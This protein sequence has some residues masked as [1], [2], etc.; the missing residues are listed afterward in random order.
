MLRAF[1]GLSGAVGGLALVVFIGLA[2]ILAH[3]PINLASL[4]PAIERSLDQRFGD[5]YVFSLGPTSIGRGAN[6]LGL[7]VEGLDIKDRSGHSVLSAPTGHVGLDFVSLMMF[8]VKVKRLEIDKIDLRLTVQPNGSVSLAAAKTP[9]AVTIDL[10]PPSSGG[11]SETN[12]PLVRLAALIDAITGAAQTVD[13][14]AIGQGHL[15]I[16]DQKTG[17][18]AAF[19][20]VDINFDK[21]ERV[22][23]LRISAKGPS[24]PWSLAAQALGGESRSLNLEA[25]D[26]SLPD[27]LLA[28]GRTLPF[29]ADMPISFNLSLQLAGDKTV[30]D[31]RGRVSLGAGYFKLD[32]PD[33]EPFLIDE[34]SADV[35][36]DPPS[37][38]ILAENVQLFAGQTHVV[39][40]GAVAP[41]APGEQSWSLDF[42]GDGA[43]I[44]GERPGEQPLAFKTASFQAHYFERDQRFTVDKFAVSGVGANAVL[45]GEI[46]ATA[47]GPT[48]KVKLDMTQTSGANLVR[49]WPTFIV[50][51]VRFWL[52]QHLRAGEI[53]TASLLLDWDAASFTAAREK[54]A[55]PADSVHIELATRDVAIDLLPGV[56]PLI[57]LEATGVLTGRNI[58]IGAK[59]GTVELTP[60]RRI[61]ASDLSFVIPD[62]SPRALVPAQGGARLQGS[63][64]ALAD[65]L[66]RDA[67]KSFVGLSLDP[68]ATKGQFDGK[69]SIDLKLGKTAKPDDIGFHA[70]GT[71]SN[72]Q[73]DKFLGAEHFDQGELAFS[74]DRGGIKISGEGKIAG[75]PVSVDLRK[76][77]SDE[78][79]VNLALSVD[80]AFRAKH[81]LDF[82]AAVSGPMS[83]QIAA[84]LSRKGAEVEI[85]LARVALDNPVPGLVKPAG[86]PGKAAFSVKSEA[87]GLTLG[88]ID[89]E[90]GGASIKGSARLTNDGALASAKLTQVRLSPGDDMKVDIAAADS[91]LKVSA[92][93]SVLDVR[94]LVK[95]AIDRRPSG[96][97]GRDV[98]FDLKVATATG[99]NKHAMSQ[100]ELTSSRR[101]GELQRVEARARLGT[102]TVGLTR[103]GGTTHIVTGDAGALVK[104]FD[105]YAHLEGGSLDLTM[106]D[107]AEGQSGVATVKDFALRNEPA[108]RQLAA[109]GQVPDKGGAGA[110]A[111]ADVAFQKMTAQFVRSTGR[112]DL[113]EAV[114]YNAQTGLTTQGF[115]DYA[116]DKLD[117]N[118]T[119]V[120]GYQVNSAVTHI[121]VLGALLG[122]GTHEGLF[123][124]NYRI[125]GP[126]SAPVLNVN[127]LSAIA[128][129]FLRKIFGALDGTTPALQSAPAPLEQ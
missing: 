5:Q 55:V 78:G 33:H 8:E 84:P 129:G 67:L 75:L 41:P 29:E 85:D 117:L 10:A 72:L 43:V 50:P 7:I 82:G 21:G 60:T 3:G 99:A 32:D 35:R 22:A 89:V 100:V 71:L 38:R 76:T 95:A 109:A 39:V 57:G 73:I 20:D 62:T 47:D 2:L 77:A 59:R 58:T 79:S 11:S 68:A 106:H 107:V 97:L 108:M 9:D 116:H 115:I 56:P 30:E 13:Y 80:D 23:G 69:L 87:D 19:D 120:P 103:E 25:R 52:V 121:P 6:G 65:L 51:D 26:L 53:Q 15:E 17:R 37:K 1:V 105:I 125:T 126:A 16:Q 88:S 54:R 61:A 86:K 128:P 12:A 74:G 94:R 91:L 14:I 111:E 98:D 101:G 44:G 81:G 34:A 119:F 114:I 45:S 113:R 90:A 70:N 66:G 104:F 49:L 27:M 83:V 31:L 24:G 48:A 112:V 4:A 124:V 46:A 102:S 63:A 127:P 93:G 18:T 40:N 28:S 96:S 92:H 42:N 122:G 123:G 64:E 110:A 118:G 36:L